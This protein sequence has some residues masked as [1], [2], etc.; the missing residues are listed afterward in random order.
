LDVAFLQRRCRYA[1]TTEIPSISTEFQVAS[2]GMLQ[3]CNNKASEGPTVLARILKNLTRQFRL[4]Q[5]EK[6]TRQKKEEIP[7]WKENRV[8]TQETYQVCLLAAMPNVDRNGK[9]I[10]TIPD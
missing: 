1:T 4:P 9:K 3:I 2:K 5:G 8:G 7:M 10:A 6:I